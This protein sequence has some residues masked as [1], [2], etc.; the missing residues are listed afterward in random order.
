MNRDG[1]LRSIAIV[2]GGTAGWMA[3]AALSRVLGTQRIAITLVESEEIGTIGVG[4]ATIPPIQS[5]N[6]LLGLDEDE[7]VRETMGSFKLG[8]EFVDWLRPG[9][10]YFHPFGTY[11]V[12]AGAVPF[13]AMWHRLRQAGQAQPLDAY[14]IC[15]AAAAGGR[16][17]RPV[18]GGNSPL[19][20]IGYAFHFD[21]GLYARYLRRHA[22][23]AGVVR[24]EG[25][26]GQVIRRAPDGFIEAV[27]LAGGERIAADLFIDCSGFRGLLIGEALGA[28]FE[29]WS[30][31]LPNDRA[32]AVPSANNGPPTPFT[33]STARAAGW[34]WRIPLQ[35]RTG[36]G[37]V[38]ASGD[39]SDDEA[40]ATLLANLDGEALAEPRLLRFRTGRRE[41]F[42]VGNC[43]ALGLASGFMEPLESTSI[44]LVQA[45]IARLLEMLPT[46]AFE[47]ADTRR[48]NRLMTAEFETIRDFLILH[49]HATERDDT[50]YWRRLRTM[51]VPE[52][53]AERIRIYRATG[54]IFREADELFTRTSWLAVMDGQGLCAR[55][56]DPLAA[57]MPLADAAGRLDRIAHVTAL[58]AQRMPSHADFIAQ[59][60]GGDRSLGA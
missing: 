36:N 9:H 28:G 10:R 59:R 51:A 32:V 49:F 42:W 45:G 24:R 47:P 1:P 23:A 21:A 33:R 14:S 16:F 53:L 56:H 57:T 27:V 37:Y 50:A 35:H 41:A 55:G 26:V 40:T 38:Y 44:H 29:D 17:M 60:I 8:I 19:S 5:F 4:E 6:A 22:E 12:D 43:V 34:Q 52:T 18:P 13:E 48:Y 46:R 39:L 25:R 2:G 3:A 7:F 20:H 31:W 15:A 11:G 30:A 58:A 54:R